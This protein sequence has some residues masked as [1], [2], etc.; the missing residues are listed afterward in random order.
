MRTPQLCY[1]ENELYHVAELLTGK[2]MLYIIAMY[3]TL[4]YIKV[5]GTGNDINIEDSKTH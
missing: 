2:Q 3:A 4:C 5:L 1:M